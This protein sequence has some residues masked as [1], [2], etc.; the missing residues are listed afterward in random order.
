MFVKDYGLYGTIGGIIG[1]VVT[2]LLKNIKQRESLAKSL[3][4]ELEGIK[5]QWIA[6]SGGGLQPLQSGQSP[7][8]VYIHVAED[9]FTVFN[10]NSDKIGLLKDLDAKKI[11]K[12][13]IFAKGFVDS[14][15]TWEEE[16]KHHMNAGQSSL[17]HFGFLE[18]YNNLY[19][20][21]TRLFLEIDEIKEDLNKYKSWF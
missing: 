12:L 7:P 15:R 18:Y 10:N 16:I 13:Y 14:L 5:E 21:Q 9:Y 4:A 11:I 3:I 2:A 1:S 8:L 17:N 6:S 19:V 20:S